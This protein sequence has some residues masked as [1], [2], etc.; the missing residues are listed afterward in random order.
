MS[1]LFPERIETDRLVLVP[2]P[3]SHTDGNERSG[4]SVGSH[5]PQGRSRVF[6]HELALSER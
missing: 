6:R 3:A 4:R 1:D 5:R 2:I